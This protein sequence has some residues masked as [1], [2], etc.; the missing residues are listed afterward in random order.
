[1]NFTG[2]SMRD[3]YRERE[4]KRKRASSYDKTGGN[5]DFDLIKPKAASEIFNVKGTG[6]ITHIWGCDSQ[7][8]QRF[9]LFQAGFMP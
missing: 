3:I 2:T 1:M 9:S 6:C 8:Q 4:G 7:S 5:F